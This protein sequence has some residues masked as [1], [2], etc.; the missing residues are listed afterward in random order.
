MQVAKVLCEVE[1]AENLNSMGDWEIEKDVAVI[2]DGILDV[3]EGQAKAEA[4]A[5]V[6]AEVEI[7]EVALEAEQLR[8][9]QW[10]A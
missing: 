6:G 9:E 5:G 1:L 8:D 7:I 2:V 10:V 3:V 4:G